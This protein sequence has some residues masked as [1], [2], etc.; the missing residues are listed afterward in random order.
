MN[1]LPQSLTAKTH[2][3]I[4]IPKDAEAVWHI[5]R[6]P[7]V[8]TMVSILPTPYRLQDA[9]NWCAPSEELHAC[10]L[11]HRYGVWLQTQAGQTLLGCAGIHARTGLPEIKLPDEESTSAHKKLE[12]KIAE[13]GYWLN[14]LFWGRGWGSLVVEQLVKRAFSKVITPHGVEGYHALYAT[15]ALDNLASQRVLAKAGFQ[16][17]GTYKILTDKGVLRPSNVYTISRPSG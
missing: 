6:T 3:R 2:W 7:E 11:E 16:L 17:Q 15:T 14:P 12:G 13:I 5:T 9:L 8:T 10:G 1:V 4:L